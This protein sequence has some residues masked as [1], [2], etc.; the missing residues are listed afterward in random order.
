MWLPYFFVIGFNKTTTY[1]RKKDHKWKTN[2]K[3]L[4]NSLWQP[5][6]AAMYLS[7]NL[8]L[9]YLYLT[10]AYRWCFYQLFWS[11]H[12]F[13]GCCSHLPA[14]TTTMALWM[15][16]SCILV[17]YVLMV[18]MPILASSG[19]NTNIWSVG[20]SLCATN[21]IRSLLAGRFSLKKY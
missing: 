8:L 16:S 12:R 11:S 2:V 9:S 1:Q 20:S 6:V 10:Y 15:F 13:N 17:Q 7:I 21:T 5:L 3:N 19:K 14:C 18:L 4:I